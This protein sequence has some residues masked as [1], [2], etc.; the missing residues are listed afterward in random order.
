L[1]SYP[2]TSSALPV[3]L[4][5]YHSGIGRVLAI[6]FMKLTTIFLA[7]A[8]VGSIYPALMSGGTVAQAVGRM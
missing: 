6:S 5:V 4:L 3:R 2:L 1:G 7:A 8:Q